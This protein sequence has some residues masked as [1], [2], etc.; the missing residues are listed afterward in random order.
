[1]MWASSR[2]GHT[3][4]QNPSRASPSHITLAIWVRVRV[5]GDTHIIRVLGMGMHLS[6][7]QRPSHFVRENPWRQGCLSLRI[8]LGWAVSITLTWGRGRE[9]GRG[10]VGVGV[11]CCFLLT[12][13]WNRKINV[14][15]EQWTLTRRPQIGV[16]QTR[17]GVTVSV[18]FTKKCHK[19]NISETSCHERET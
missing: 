6:L 19:K 1:M 16:L 14:T 12:K 17:I 4:S 8:P 7:W 18:S 11:V 10:W 2:F 13:T 3:H 9:A 15:K 5:T